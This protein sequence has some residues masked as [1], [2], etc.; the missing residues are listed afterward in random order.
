M[1]KQKNYSAVGTGQWDI[2][3]NR[4]CSITMMMMTY[5]LCSGFCYV[6]DVSAGSVWRDKFDAIGTTIES[7]R[8]VAIIYSG[9][10]Q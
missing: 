3:T 4:F 10:G 9:D 2:Y 5:T 1:M 8:T 6:F 7:T